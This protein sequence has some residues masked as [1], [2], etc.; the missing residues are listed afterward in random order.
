M[1]DAVSDAC[2]LAYHKQATSAMVRFLRLPW[3]V[4]LF[5]ELPVGTCLLDGEPR[6][7]PHPAAWARELAGWLSLP[8]S[9]VSG[10]S[11]FR[12]TLSLPNGGERAVLLLQLTGIDPPFEAAARRQGRFIT[13]LE[14]RD[15]A[16]AELE[17]L[18]AGYEYLMGG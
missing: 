17:L 9:V 8:A 6:L 1:N 10:D 14:A 4:T 2:L 12:R 16:R 5:E 3:G 7:A 11:D 13:L 18:R 15:L